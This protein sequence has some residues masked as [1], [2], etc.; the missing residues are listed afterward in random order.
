MLPFATAADIQEQSGGDGYERG[1]QLFLRLP[2]M[3]FHNITVPTSSFGAA[4]H[5]G[6]SN[7]PAVGRL[8]GTAR[9]GVIQS[10]NGGQRS[11]SRV[12]RRQER[13]AWL[14]EMRNRQNQPAAPSPKAVL[15]ARLLV[16]IVRKQIETGVHVDGTCLLYTSDAADE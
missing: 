2:L 12:E 5:N 1:C 15:H 10:G 16:N 11:I 6:P 13:R 9:D 7:V 3:S 8:G 14:K 4:N